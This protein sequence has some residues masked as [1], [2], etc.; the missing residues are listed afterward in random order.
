MV[1]RAPT[2]YKFSAKNFDRDFRYVNDPFDLLIQMFLFQKH[3]VFCLFKVTPRI[4]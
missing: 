1:D 4:V 2:I 3:F